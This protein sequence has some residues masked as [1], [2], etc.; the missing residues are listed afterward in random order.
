M[1]FQ[2]YLTNEAIRVAPLAPEGG[3]AV[4]EFRGVVRGTENGEPIAALEY[5]A[6]RPMTERI[7]ERILRQLE[8]RHSCIAVHVAH[9]LGVIPVGEIAI[10][11]GVTAA[12]RADGLSL[13]AVLLDRLKLDVPIWKVRAIRSLQEE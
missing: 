7:L 9:R 4:I 11:V 6:Y 12:H 2:I 10:Y 5:E 3:G 1:R 8:T 13:I